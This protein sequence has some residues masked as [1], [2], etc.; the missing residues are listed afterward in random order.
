[1]TLIRLICT[2]PVKYL[3]VR[4]LTALALIHLL[5]L[6]ASVGANDKDLK[7]HYGLI[8]GTAYGPDDRGVYGAKIEIHPAGKKHPSWELFSDHRGEF[9]QRVPPGPADYVITGEVEYTPVVN[10]ATQKK[11]K[12]KAEVKVHIE[13]E[14]RQDVSLHFSP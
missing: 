8:F 6:S 12:L 3:R 14:E 13:G 7:K 2:D 9:A 4:P 1:M 11:K 5:V 10:G